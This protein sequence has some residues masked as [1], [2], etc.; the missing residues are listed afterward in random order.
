MLIYEDFVPWDKIP[1]A[2]K[3]A[4]SSR[5]VHRLDISPYKVI[6]VGATAKAAIK[7]KSALTVPEV[8]TRV[9]HY[10]VSLDEA[11]G[12]E[13]CEYFLFWD[14]VKQVPLIAVIGVLDRT[15]RTVIYARH[16]SG[17]PVALGK[18]TL[19]PEEWYY[20]TWLE[21]AASL[22]LAGLPDALL[23]VPGVSYEVRWVE[24]DGEIGVD[25]I[26]VDHASILNWRDYLPEVIDEA[27]E[28]VDGARQASLCVYAGR[29]K[30]NDLLLEIDLFALHTGHRRSSFW[31]AATVPS[32]L[33][34]PTHS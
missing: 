20:P 5:K 1:E 23:R 26:K 16:E 9:H 8:L 4:G 34:I 33:L 2:Q 13:G 31:D 27:T 3:R 7:E 21:F 17:R 28:L 6:V 32:N 24:A 12:I 14:P 25:T 22:R 10:S 29:R 30:R 11:R 18:E 15:M 19:P